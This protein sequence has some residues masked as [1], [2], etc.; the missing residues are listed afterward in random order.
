MQAKDAH[1]SAKREG[2][3][4]HISERASDGEPNLHAN[5][6]VS[7]GWQATTRRLSTEARSAEGGRQPPFTDRTQPTQ[8][9]P[10]LTTYSIGT[11]IAYSAVM[12]LPKCLVYILRSKSQPTR[13]YTGLTSHVKLRLEAHNTGQCVHTATGRP[14]EVD[15]V[16]EFVR[17]TG[18]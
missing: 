15:V 14:W 13:Y 10:T 8:R 4:V 6:R 5:E 7:Y 17:P 12:S 18:R 2:G 3:P 11:R 16:N 9:A 1:R